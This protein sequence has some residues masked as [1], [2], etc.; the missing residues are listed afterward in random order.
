MGDAI[1]EHIRNV[2]NDT[3]TAEGVEIVMR[4]RNTML[5]NR[6]PNDLL[7]AGEFERLDEWIGWLEAGPS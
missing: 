5:D 1:R 6:S 7:E 2:L 3:Y 4:S